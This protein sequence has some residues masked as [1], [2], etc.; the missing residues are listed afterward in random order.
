MTECGCEV[1]LA[2]TQ[3]M[4][5]RGSPLEAPW[6]QGSLRE[7][8]VSLHRSALFLGHRQLRSQIVLLWLP[9]EGGSSVFSLHPG[10]VSWCLAEE[11]EV[12]LMGRVL[13]TAQRSQGVHWHQRG[14][15]AFSSGHVLL[16]Q[17][18]LEVEELL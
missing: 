5:A 11:A 4:L 1:G 10:W 7:S 14:Y 16:S 6:A 2:L 9:K 18:F 13:L 3:L 17:F 12:M 8:S 15:T